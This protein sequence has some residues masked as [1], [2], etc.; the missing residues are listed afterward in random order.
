[1]TDKHAGLPVLIVGITGVVPEP[2]SVFGQADPVNSGCPL[3]K[4]QRY[5]R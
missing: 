1:L 2:D 4:F 3:L 5:L